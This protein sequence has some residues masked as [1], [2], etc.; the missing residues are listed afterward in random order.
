[1]VFWS[2]K[3]RLK[4]LGVGIRPHLST[5]RV[6]NNL[7]PTCHLFLQ[8]S[9]PS[10]SLGCLLHLIF[11]CWLFPT[12]SSSTLAFWMFTGVLYTT[13]CFSFDLFS[14]SNSDQPAGNGCTA[15]ELPM[16]NRA[17]TWSLAQTS[18]NQSGAW[19]EQGMVLLPG[20][21]D[22]RGSGWKRR[23][24]LLATGSTEGCACHTRK[25]GFF[26]SV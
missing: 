12:G 8:L 16:G 11:R 4:G 13:L 25:P 17:I 9:S 1:M 20:V 10:A 3:P 14:W 26:P 6:A 7:S 23:L 5:G 21:Q 19:Q 15:G 2:S 24:G 18:E 22:A